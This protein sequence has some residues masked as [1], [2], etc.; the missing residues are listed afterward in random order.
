MH[1]SRGSISGWALRL[2]DPRTKWYCCTLIS[3]AA[4]PTKPASVPRLPR[5][6]PGSG[7]RRRLNSRLNKCVTA[8]SRVAG[9]FRVARIDGEPAVDVPINAHTALAA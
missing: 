2:R 7:R 4:V 9:M 5:E 3:S 8:V 1:Y 6:M